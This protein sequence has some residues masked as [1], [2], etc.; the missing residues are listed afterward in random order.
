MVDYVWL[1]ADWNAVY[2]FIRI[3]LSFKWSCSNFYYLDDKKT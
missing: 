2:I 1:Y 3:E